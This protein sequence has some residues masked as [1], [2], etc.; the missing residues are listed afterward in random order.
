MKSL[1]FVVV[2][3]IA[4]LSLQM[5]AASGGAA[6]NNVVSL[7]GADLGSV[8]LAVVDGKPLTAA[9]VRDAVLIAAKVQ[10]FS[11]GRNG[12]QPSGRRANLAAMHLAPKLVSSMI[13]DAELD[14]RGIK[15]SAASEAAVLSKYNDKFKRKSKT[16]TELFARFGKLAP[17]FKRQFVR[18]SRYRELFDS[19]PEL[20]VTE[21]DINKFYSDISNR[22]VKCE[23][24]NR[25]AKTQIENA[26]KELNAGRPWDV[27]AT[28]YTEDALLHK[29]LAENWKDW[30]SV[31]LD[32]LEPVEL[33]AAVSKLKPGEFT[34]PVETEEGVVIVKLLERDGDMCSMARIL[35]RMAVSVDVPSREQAIKKLRKG[36][37]AVFQRKTLAGLKKSAKI[38][39]PFGKKFVF[40]IWDEPVAKPNPGG[41]NDQKAVGK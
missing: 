23:R 37:E 12:T 8:S 27:V 29:S 28:N 34:R 14:R 19:L 40:K 22:L 36:K 17:A 39:Y 3:C 24:I 32:K 1:R 11:T 15:A 13:L 30:I 2:G 33:K 16:N 20:K 35:L 31:K 7:V 21:D 6:T 9:Q 26:W 4:S 38:E 5:M 18:E 25:R 41:M 10:D